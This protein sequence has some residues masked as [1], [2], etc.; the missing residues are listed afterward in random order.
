[1]Q[2]PSEDDL[3]HFKEDYGPLQNFVPDHPLNTDAYKSKLLNHDDVTAFCFFRNQ[4]IA[5]YIFTGYGDGLI[6]AWDV[7]SLQ[8]SE[9]PPDSMPLIGHT[10]KINHL[11]AVQQLGKL[12][13]CSND[14]TLR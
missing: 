14:C 5:Q 7:S 11:E 4:Q 12:F 3:Y 6:C 9:L 13:S 2:K 1:M 10:N 8:P